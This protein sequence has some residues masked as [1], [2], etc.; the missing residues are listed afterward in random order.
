[1]KIILGIDYEEGML[2]V[3]DHDEDDY[4]IDDVKYSR[5]GSTVLW[6]ENPPTCSKCIKNKT[7]CSKKCYNFVALRPSIM[8]TI[9]KSHKSKQESKRQ[10]IKE[11]L[12]KIKDM[13]KDGLDY[14]SWLYKSL[15]QSEDNTE[16]MTFKPSH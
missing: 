14:E 15:F 8:K 7:S 4:D 1:M 16:R 13:K 2:Q 12:Q 5:I 6:E 9:T 10:L 3:L 11:E